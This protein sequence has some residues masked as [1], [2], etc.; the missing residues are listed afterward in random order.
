MTAFMLKTIACVGMLLDHIYAAFPYSTPRLLNSIGRFVFPVYA[1]MIAQGCKHTKSINKYLIRLG[2]F[3]LI[4]EIP[5]DIAFMSGGAANIASWNINFLN[6]TNVFYTLLLGV[7]CIAVYE[8]TKKKLSVL[9]V[10]NTKKSKLFRSIL[11]I[12]PMIPLV[13]LGSILNTDYGMLGIIF[14]VVFYFA[15]PENKMTRTVAAAIIVFYEYGYPYIF[16]LFH[17]RD[18]S[19]PYLGQMIIFNAQSVMLN[20]FMF[21]LIAVLLIFLYNGKQ[22]AN[23]KWAFYAYYPLHIAALVAVRLIL[24]AR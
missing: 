19:L 22:G 1:Y 20:N 4:S 24:A 23:S 6:Q 7:A 16:V 17:E 13:I 12:L 5:F 9:E 8:K 3:A 11:P 2:I 18:I 21:A 15:K 10:N 14:I